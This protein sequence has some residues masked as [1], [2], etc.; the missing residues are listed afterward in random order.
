MHGN[1]KIPADA[2]RL[3]EEERKGKER[4]TEAVVEGITLPTD[5][6]G[7]FYFSPVTITFAL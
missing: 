6:Q 1:L 2:K 5:L 3:E 4:I 7:C